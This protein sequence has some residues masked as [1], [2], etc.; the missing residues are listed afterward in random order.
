MSQ[1]PKPIIGISCELKSPSPK[2]NFSRKKEISVLNRDYSQ[3]ILRAGGVPYL[4]PVMNNDDSLLEICNLL[5]GLILSGGSDVVL[6][7]ENWQG[8]PACEENCL[9]ETRLLT[10]ALQKK[11][12]ILGICRGLQQLNVYFG[13]DLWPDLPAW[14]EN[15]VDHRRGKKEGK[16]RHV[17][18]LSAEVSVSRDHWPK[19][20]FVNSSHHQAARNPG[21]GLRPVAW[22]EDGVIEALEAEDNHTLWAVQWHPE[23]L[24]DHPAGDE[25][26]RYFIT[27]CVIR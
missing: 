8:D 19:K 20:F 11:L 21:A 17:L 27:S 9:H 24:G 15:A 3:A 16:F 23:R 25:L 12:P 10:F 6:P 7:G 13:G 2:R 14:K 1:I 5:D 4:I 18:K 22:A 26:L